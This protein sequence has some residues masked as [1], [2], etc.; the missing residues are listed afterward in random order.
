MRQDFFEYDPHFKLLIIGNHKP[1]LRN[2]D[3]AMRRRLNIVPFVLKPVTIDKDLEAKLLAEGP[4][5]LQWMI[6]GCLD[7]Q[8]NGLVRPE[9]VQSATAEYFSDQDTVN[10]W[11]DEYCDVRPGAEPPIWDLSS[12]LF[13]SW[14]KYCEQV[15]EDPGTQ[16][17][18]AASLQRRGIEKYRV[19]GRGSRAFRGARLKQTAGVFGGDQ[20]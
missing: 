4:S 10:A 1:T 13:G 3:E 14:K 7:W 9:V 6:Q 16:K 20:E 8:T 19:P 17:A 11:L 5:I 15:G 12:D 18:F 2:I